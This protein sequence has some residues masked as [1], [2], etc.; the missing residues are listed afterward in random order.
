M[1]QIKYWLFAG[2]LLALV[3]IGAFNP[4]RAQA[5]DLAPFDAGQPL[6][7]GMQILKE[8]PGRALSVADLANAHGWQ[9]ASPG[10]VSSVLRASTTWLTE[11]VSNNSPEPI[12]RWISVGYWRLA[13]VQMFLLDPLTGQVQSHMHAG[14]KQPGSAR[15]LTLPTMESVFP[16]ELEPGQQVQMVLR[17]QS[18]GW[19]TIAVE[20]WS[21]SSYLSALQQTR[22]LHSVI[23]GIALASIFLLLLSRQRLYVLLATWLAIAIASVTLNLGYGIPVLSAWLPGKSLSALV[24]TLA[25]WN[26]LFLVLISAVI[27][28]LDKRDFWRRV[29]AGILVISVTCSALFFFIDTLWVRRILTIALLA[30]LAVLPIMLWSAR[31]RIPHSSSRLM[32]VL[33]GLAW[34][35][36]AIRVVAF[37][38][39]WLVDYEK[40]I[41][42]ANVYSQVA[43][44]LLIIGHVAQRQRERERQMEHRAKSLERD[45]RVQL[46]TLVRQRTTELEHSMLAAQEATKAKTEFLRHVGHDLRSPMAT[47]MGYTEMLQAR[48][49]TGSEASRLA[50]IHRTTDHMLNVIDDLIDY[51]HDAGKDRIDPQPVYTGWLIDLIAQQARALAETNAN[52]FVLKVENALPAVIIVDGK[53]LRRIL[54]SLLDNSAKFTHDGQIVLHIR[55]QLGANPDQV[56]MHFMVGDTGCGIDSDEQAKLFLP[57]FRGRSSQGSPGLGLGL[58]LASTWVQHMG[59]T[60]HVNSQ[61]NHGTEVTIELSFPIGQERDVQPSETLGLP[62]VDIKGNGRRLWLVE[63]IPEVREFLADWLNRHGFVVLQSP[64]GAAFIKTMQTTA[65]APP[66]AVLTDYSMP[67]AGG[68][69]VLAAVRLHWPDVPVLLLSAHITARSS[70]D[71]ALTPGFDA[72]LPKPIDFSIL[73]GELSRLLD[74][75]NTLLK[76]SSKDVLLTDESTNHESTPSHVTPQSPHSQHTRATAGAQHDAA[77]PQAR[78]AELSRLVEEGALTDIEDWAQT[79]RT[80]LP[81]HAQFALEV[82]RLVEDLDL[83]A[84][85]KLIAQSQ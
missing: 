11:T 40:P 39:N 5:I 42:L 20:S 36:Q 7:G 57:F 71:Q 23:A 29:L 10:N 31:H 49:V 46:E 21:P 66:S 13:D 61:P 18:G 50:V 26:S 82:E 3:L 45:Q 8:Q 51:T 27:L 54:L 85:N 53:R 55:C 80:D 78:L 1:A 35:S 74:P 6:I 14:L 72:F 19:R 58:R 32:V 47:I 12:T 17:V 67:G 70:S 43:I 37:A 9:P 41:Y 65:E 84:L 44:L 52:Q 33:L 2:F 16:I 79:L 22:M 25:F 81:E 63:D 69:A 59:G 77:P 56:S 75:D 15:P 60:L 62:P 73:A 83:H 76:P 68:D 48:I 38:T 64:D 30:L 4:A 34:A 24:A 28:G